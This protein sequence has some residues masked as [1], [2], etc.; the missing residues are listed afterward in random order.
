MITK[1]PKH[2]QPLTF[3]ERILLAYFDNLSDSDKEK[4][5]EYTKTLYK[6]RAAPKQIGDGPGGKGD[7]Q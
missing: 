7:C 3:Q 2:A 6:N 5:I 1:F 4:V